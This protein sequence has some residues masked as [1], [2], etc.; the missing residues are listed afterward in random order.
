MSI[1]GGDFTEE[2]LIN[3][4]EKSLE[5]IT[6]IIHFIGVICEPTNWLRQ[7][8]NLQVSVL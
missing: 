7:S 6:V 5:I 8:A 4:E 1:F 3:M 2:S